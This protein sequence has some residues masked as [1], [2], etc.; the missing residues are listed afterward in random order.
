MNLL[1]ATA[2]LPSAVEHRRAH[3]ELL[4]HCEDCPRELQGEYIWIDG[5][6]PT[7]KLRSK[8]KIIAG[9]AQ[10]GDLGLRRL[11]HV[12]GGG[13]ASDR[14]SR[15]CSPS[16]T[17]S[18]AKTTSSC[19]TRS[20]IPTAASPEQHPRPAAPGRGEVRPSS[21]GSGSSRSTPSSRAR[22]LGWPENGF[23]APQGGYYCGV[24]A[25]EVFGRDIIEAHLSA[26]WPPAGIHRHQRRGHAWPMGVPGRPAGTAGGLR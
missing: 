4:T 10:P 7:A 2:D 19:S 8:T 5:T 17:P 6:E 11:Q 9:G 15:R 21:R 12:P 20:S 14:G 24:G 22:P 1:Q 13:P 16:R 26:A 3:R 18:A 23:P 25:D